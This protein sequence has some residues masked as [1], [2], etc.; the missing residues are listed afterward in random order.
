VLGHADRSRIVGHGTVPWTDVGWGFV[1]VDG[2]TTARWRLFTDG[3]RSELRVEPFR[4]ISRAERQEVT[5]EAR[6]LGAFLAP[7]DPD[8]A[9][10]IAAAR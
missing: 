8:V 1:L 3:A 10:R 7:D 2:F 6:R 9:I 4:R 5:D